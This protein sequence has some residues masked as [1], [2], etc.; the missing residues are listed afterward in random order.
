MNNVYSV[1]QIRHIEQA[2]MAQ[3]HIDQADE[4]LMQSAGL[5]AATVAQTLVSGPPE[6]VRV[7]IL[8]GPGN[9]GGDALEV[10]YQLA[11]AKCQ[12]F[13]LL[14][15]PPTQDDAKAAWQRAQHSP[16]QFL[17][18][19]KCKDI[20]SATTAYIASQVWDLIV[21]GLFGIGLCRPITGALKRIIEIINQIPCP[22]LALDVPSG[23]NADTGNI[24]GQPDHTANIALRASHTI[25]FIGD[26]PG[27]HTSYGRDYAG[28]VL[29]SNLGIAPHHFMS[30]HVSLNEI[31]LFKAYLRQRA[32]YSH[33][34]SHG[35]VAVIGGAQGTCGALILAARA[36]LYCGAGRVFA[37]FLDQAPSFD[38]NQPELM[39]RNAHELDMS[40]TTLLIGPG[41]GMSANARTL[42][43][44]TLTSERPRVLDADALNLIALEPGLQ[45]QV[46][47]ASAPCIIT[48][49][50]L[51]A[52]RLLA[53]TVG[54][55]EADRIQAAQ[56]L[57]QKFN[58]TVIL[59]GSGSVIAGSHQQVAINTTGNPALASGGT[60]DVLAGVCVTFLAQGWPAWEAAL[61]A[62]WLHG[63]AAD[64]LVA[65]G[66]G[67]IGLCAGEL[68]PA[69]RHE[70]NLLVKQFT[71][72]SRAKGQVL[73]LT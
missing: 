9:N 67:P 49:H 21:D 40:R 51:E 2:A 48:P 63:R 27:L 57:A 41:L 20:G 38:A 62:T 29:V 1:A 69:I 46:V 36:A 52:A 39:C 12:V 5:A 54:A 23:L 32:H 72:P 28:E 50:P 13:V 7:L 61:A 37:A 22:R 11:I 26:K 30:S 42:L 24:I 34:G 25:T 66:T 45:E 8:A 16:V 15:A 73:H 58:C 56:A 53:C 44:S 3:R 4:S 14:V 17:D 31:A 33:K 47:G 70:I 55:I 18:L 64:R 71:E 59:K 10:A 35:D 60:G 6:Q 19:S 43:L 65:Q 68:L